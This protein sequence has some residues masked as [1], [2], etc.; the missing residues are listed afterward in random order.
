MAN[1]PTGRAPA[2]GATFSGE[3]K[4]ERDDPEIALFG[5]TGPAAGTPISGRITYDTDA[6]SAVPAIDTATT[7]AWSSTTGTVAN[8][9]IRIVET[10]NGVTVVFDGS[11]YSGFIVARGPGPYPYGTAAQA[12]EIVSETSPAAGTSAAQLNFVSSNPS[13]RIASPDLSPGGPFDLSAIEHSPSYFGSNWATPTLAAI[14]NFDVTAASA[15]EPTSL[16]IMLA[17][18]LALLVRRRR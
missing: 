9:A 6:F 13:A 15:P 10:I 18:C 12:L 3:C 4:R 1:P 7:R 17:P 16:A 8:G 14:W 11:Y 5:L 2:G